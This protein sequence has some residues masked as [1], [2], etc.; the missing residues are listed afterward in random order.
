MTRPDQTRPDQTSYLYDFILEWLDS[1]ALF[2]FCTI[3]L[4]LT[5]SKV[6]YKFLFIIPSEL[7]ILLCDVAITS[8]NAIFLDIVIYIFLRRHTILHKFAKIILLAASICM[9]TVD[10]FALYNFAMPFNLV[11]LDTV[12]MTNFHEAVEFV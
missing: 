9:F 1:E 7:L 3:F 10:I 5:A 2:I 6:T 4:N 12:L 11:M 8:F